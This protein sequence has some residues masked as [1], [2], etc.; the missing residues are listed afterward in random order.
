MN[1]IRVATELINH[2]VNDLIVER[3]E[4]LEVTVKEQLDS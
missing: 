1:A 3:W 4:E 2:H